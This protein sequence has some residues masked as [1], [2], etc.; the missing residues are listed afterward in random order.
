MEVVRVGVVGMGIG[1][2]NAKAIAANPRGE[3]VALCD[4]LEER[5][6]EVAADL[7]QRPR[8]FTDYEAMCADADIDAIMVGTPNQLHVPMAEKALKAGKHVLVT[9]PLADSPEAAERVVALAEQLDLV[10]MMSLST[11]FSG[12]VQYLGGLANGGDLG[13]LY[14]ARARSVRRNGIPHWGAHFIQKGGGAFRDMGV[15][16]LDAAWWLIGRPAPVSALGVAGAKF[17][18]RGRGYSREVPEEYWRQYAA[19]DYGCGIIRFENGAAIQVESFWA[20]HQPNEVNVELFGTEGG[21]VLRPL[22]VYKD[23]NGRPA[24]LTIKPP[25]VGG[26]DGLAAH[27]IEC[28]LDGVECDAP[29]RDGMVVQR[30]LEAVLESSETGGE[31]RFS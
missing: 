30:M 16:V 6:E 4:L 22:T 11:R 25:D 7:P 21:A 29:L 20:S 8:F 10:N 18:P 28:I 27:F 24:D 17:G 31:V 5:M 2:A 3:V 12:A 13:E 1:R 9:K 19:D 15:H 14:Y 23:V 26:F